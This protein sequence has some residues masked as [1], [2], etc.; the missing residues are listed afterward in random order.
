[1]NAELQLVVCEPYAG[2][3]TMKACVARYRG[4]CGEGDYWRGV[5]AVDTVK[6]LDC[7]AGRQRSKGEG[8]GGLAVSGEGVFG[9]PGGHQGEGE[10]EP[11]SGV[12]GKSAVECEVKTTV[13]VELPEPKSAARARAKGSVPA[14]DGEGET[15]TATP[16][17]AAEGSIMSEPNKGALKRVDA[18]CARCGGI[19]SVMP[20]HAGRPAFCDNCKEAGVR[21]TKDLEREKRQ[22]EP[23]DPFEKS[24]INPPPEATAVHQAFGRIEE[25]E[26]FV[27]DRRRA[28]EVLLGVLGREPGEVLSAEV[29]AQRAA[30]RIEQTQVFLDDYDRRFTGTR[31]ALDLASVP[32]IDRNVPNPAGRAMDEGERID[33]LARER[34]SYR[35][36]LEA[37]KPGYVG[38]PDVGQ[39]PLDYALKVH[40]MVVE[41]RAT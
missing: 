3:M 28:R 21:T 10:G 14:I 34:D 15:T 6:C 24:I 23:V 36:A 11:Q 33:L 19:T 1:M 40:R 13:S 29:L 32:S 41:G 20:M 18:P 12:A 17:P 25:L 39:L 37:V 38:L 9:L 7:P 2:K 30:E 22:R 8:V 5:A 35:A 27:D 31:N 16:P 4:R 26:A